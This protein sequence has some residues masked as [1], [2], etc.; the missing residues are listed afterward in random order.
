MYGRAYQ[1][2]AIVDGFKDRI[3]STMRYESVYSAVIEQRQL[4]YERLEHHIWQISF[5]NLLIY[6]QRAFQADYESS[7]TSDSS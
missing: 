4:R 3:T 2:H 1:W 6:L 5:L 7:F